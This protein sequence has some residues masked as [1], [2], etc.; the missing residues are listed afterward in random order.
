M[1]SVV[2]RDA[3]GQDLLM[4]LSGE[5]RK[6]ILKT[7]AHLKIARL[8]SLAELFGLFLQVFEI[9]TGR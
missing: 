7:L 8:M 6:V 2:Q 3:A 4:G 5:P 1:L 9:R